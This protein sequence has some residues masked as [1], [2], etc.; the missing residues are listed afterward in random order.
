MLIPSCPRQ[1]WKRLTRLHELFSGPA[2][3]FPE[4]S[5]VLTTDA[6]LEEP[7]NLA[8]G[9][10]PMQ[11]SEATIAMQ[12]LSEVL[13]IW[14]ER[15]H[16]AD[17]EDVVVSCIEKGKGRVHSSQTAKVVVNYLR[18]LADSKRQVEV[19]DFLEK[20]DHDLSWS[21]G[22]QGTSDCEVAGS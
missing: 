2:M 20:D 14:N 9:F 11:V 17:I 1:S 5:E 8:G 3:D 19:K 22:R 6:T 18:I 13:L 12:R 15:Q 4:L 10:G 21:S 16:D 7:Q